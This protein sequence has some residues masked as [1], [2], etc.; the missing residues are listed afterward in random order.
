MPACN[1]CFILYKEIII[2]I[3]FFIVVVVVRNR[4]A[5]SKTNG[6]GLYEDEDHS[7]VARLLFFL[8]NFYK[9]TIYRYFFIETFV[10]L[11]FILF[12]SLYQITL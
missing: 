1:V 12:R 10:S 6:S 7:H 3:Y 4:E 9:L 5:A 11:S 2:E 8:L